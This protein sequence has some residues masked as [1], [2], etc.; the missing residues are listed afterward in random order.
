M[1]DDDLTYMHRAIDAS[2]RARYTSPNPRVGAVVVSDGRI[3]GEGWHEGAGR[4]HAETQAL[5]GIDATGATMYVTL[6]PCMHHGHTGPCAPAVA[7]AGVAR[8]VVAVEDPDPR[9][10][11]KGIA[12]LRKAGVEVATGVG[13]VEAADAIAPYL[14][15]RR[16]GRAFL[17]L[18]LAV[19]LDG[20]VAAADGTS[21]WITGAETRAYVHERRVEADAVLVGA[22][23]ALAD[24]PS[25]TARD[26]QAPRQP[27]RIVADRAG[28]VPAGAKLFAEPRETLA[29]TRRADGTSHAAHDAVL[30]WKESG[31]EVLVLPATDAGV[32]VRALLEALGDRGFTEVFCEGGVTL[33]TSLLR[34]GLVDRL[35][36][37]T[38]AVMFGSGPSIGDLGLG[39]IDEASRWRRVRTVGSGDD[40]ISV[41]APEGA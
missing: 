9:V 21:R 37:H 30:S 7:E 16:T 5:A 18:K 24:D 41:Y 31:A 10:A 26:A 20:R 29:P 34:D 1:T 39:T 25:L 36:L 8:V 33:A 22:G 27:V 13:A 23:T 11:G 28:R 12:H 4:P 2:R 40:V 35:E 32:D 17:T 14:H 19:G 3:I 15:H 38:G 6:E